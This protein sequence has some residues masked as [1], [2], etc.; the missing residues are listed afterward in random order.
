MRTVTD[1]YNVYNYNELSDEAKEKAK[2]WYLDDDFRTA[3][4]TVMTEED[5]NNLFDEKLSVQYSLSNRQGDGLNI[6]GEIHA[7]SIMECLREH[8]GGEQLKQFED[9]LNEKEWKII[10]H[11]AKECDTIKL[12]ANRQ[13]CYCIADRIDVAE[14]WYYQLE[15]YSGYANINMEVLKKF[16]KLVVDIFKFLCREYEDMGY[17]FF[18]EVDDEEMEYTCEANGWE[19]L[20]NGTFYVA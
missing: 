9:R 3:E 4:F 1:V 13:Y 8:N 19:F 5:L 10:C 14:D 11:Y 18:Y 6:Y 7:E 15:N 16:E 12:P 17:K 2:Q 20:E